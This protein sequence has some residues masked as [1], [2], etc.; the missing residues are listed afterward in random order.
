M[1]MLSHGQFNGVWKKEN[2]N[3]QQNSENG[4]S[5]TYAFFHLS[6]AEHRV[7][8]IRQCVALYYAK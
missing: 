2:G 5:F 3:N 6:P 8:P 7:Q 4:K 1:H